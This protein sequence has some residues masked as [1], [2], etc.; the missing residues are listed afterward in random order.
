MT[1]VPLH[2]MLVAFKWAAP[3]MS[4]PLSEPGAG[5]D[6]RRERARH[7]RGS[8]GS[9][10][11]YALFAALVHLLAFMTSRG[12]A[13]RFPQ[14]GALRPARAIRRIAIVASR[15]GQK[16]EING[17]DESERQNFFRPKSSRFLR[18]TSA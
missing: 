5:H 10:Y 6:C 3:R 8:G 16:S 13:P 12:R 11:D 1:E 17:E 18:H 15:R 4:R 7:I 2:Y 9:L 14:A